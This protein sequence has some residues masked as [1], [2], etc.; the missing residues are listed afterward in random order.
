[1][2]PRNA[3]FFLSLIIIGT[4][5]IITLRGIA[6]TYAQTQLFFYFLGLIV[7][8]LISSK[9]LSWWKKTSWIWYLGTI[10]LLLLTLITGSLTKGAVSWLEIGAYRFQPSEFVKPV[11]LLLLAERITRENLYSWTGRMK[12]FIIVVLP[13]LLIFLQ[14]DFGTAVTIIIGIAAFYLL[15]RPP[16]KLTLALL[17]GTIVLFLISWIWLLQPYQKDRLTVFFNPQADTQASGYNVQQALI[18]VGSGGLFGQGWGR[19]QQSHLRFLPERHTDFLFAAFAEENGLVGSLALLAT[20]TFLF[21]RIG[22]IASQITN[23]QNQRLVLAAGWLIFGQTAI[24]IG[25]NLGLLPVTGVPLPLF[26]LGGSSLISTSILLGLIEAARRENFPP[27][28][29]LD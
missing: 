11:I 23:K 4:L 25:M 26:S 13:I 18:A 24:N 1:M 19:G 28:Y 2:L 29:R 3:F 5:S 22:Q 12:A 21:W 7:M 15:L 27:V 17:L 6:I 14:P 9:S 20:Y 16:Q 10:L 8:Y